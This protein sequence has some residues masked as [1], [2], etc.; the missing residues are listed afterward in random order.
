VHGASPLFY[1]V[2]S[3][4]LDAAR[5]LVERGASP[6]MPMKLGG[7]GAVTLLD[8]AVFQ[9][10]QPMVRQLAAAGLD[11]NAL[12]E[13]GLS[14]LDNA[15][16]GNDVEMARTLIALGAKVDQVDETSLTALMHAS[17]VD[18]GDTAMV[19]LLVASAPIDRRSPRMGSRR[20]TWRASSATRAARASC[21]RGARQT[22]QL[23]TRR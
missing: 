14:M 2:W 18:F 23:P 19:E 21:P 15:V 4:N 11:V 16:L 12:D 7:Q 13:Y 22:D 1:A 3:G 8:I 6:G 9:G 20:S 5:V 10:D 17:S